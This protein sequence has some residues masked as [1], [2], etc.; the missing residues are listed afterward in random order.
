[1]WKRMNKHV[2]V[3]NLWKVVSTQIFWMLFC[4]LPISFLDCFSYEQLWSIQFCLEKLWN[5][6]YNVWPVVGPLSPSVQWAPGPIGL[7]YNGPGVQWPPLGSH[8]HHKWDPMG[9]G[10]YIISKFPKKIPKKAN[11]NYGFSCKSSF[12]N[13]TVNISKKIM[14]K[15][16][17]Q[18]KVGNTHF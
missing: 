9:P 6:A 10:P 4:L 2:S 1:M 5:I 16:D 17:K 13:K 14:Q 7:G 3:K 15:H 12:F 18:K 11:M 8:G